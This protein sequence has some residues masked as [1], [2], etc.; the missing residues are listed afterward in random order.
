VLP[1]TLSFSY[2]LIWRGL[3]PSTADP[4]KALLYFVETQRIDDLLGNVTAKIAVDDAWVGANQGDSFIF[5]S[6]EP[7]AHQLCARWQSSLASRQQVSLN[8]LTA[9][10]GKAYYFLIRITGNGRTS[11]W[12]DLMKLDSDEAQLL[13][14]R[15]P[16]SVSR[17]KK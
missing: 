17:A 13:I 5:V 6:V 11:C 16:Y 7:G 2:N 12:F 15:S 14:E 4:G 10:P 9:E 3:N 8:N 1:T